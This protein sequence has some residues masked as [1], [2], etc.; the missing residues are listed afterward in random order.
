MFSIDVKLNSIE[1]I[2]RLHKKIISMKCDIDALKGSY[3][4]DAKSFMGLLTMDWS[5]PITLKFHTNDLGIRK[6]FAQ[7]L[8]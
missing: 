4:V 7:W 6:E 8:V 1:D 3:I 5:S 2:D